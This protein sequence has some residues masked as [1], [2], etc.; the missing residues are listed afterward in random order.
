MNHDGDVDPSE[1]REW[2]DA[3]GPVLAFEAPERT[4]VVL[5]GVIE[6]ARHT[7]AP[8]LYSAN[9]LYLNTIPSQALASH[10][11]DHSI[12]HRLFI[13]LNAL[14]M[15]SGPTRRSTVNAFLARP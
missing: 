14:A 15:C 3:I 12:E 1:T 9:T 4:H 2:R 7:G 6:E 11:G 8:V 13:H 5:E 10:P